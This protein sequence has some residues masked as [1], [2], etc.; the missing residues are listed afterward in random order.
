ME[1]AGPLSLFPGP[2]L[3]C[4]GLVHLSQLCEP[5]SWPSPSLC[6][7]LGWGREDWISPPPSLW[8]I[9]PCGSRSPTILFS[10]AFACP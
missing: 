8:N 10:L 4:P 2:D 1:G 9:V 7:L 3:P 6:S 5:V